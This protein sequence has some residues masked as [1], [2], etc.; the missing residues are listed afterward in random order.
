M[1]KKAKALGGTVRSCAASGPSATAS[2]NIC[3]DSHP[4]KPRLAIMV[5]AKKP[6]AFKELVRKKY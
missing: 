5:G 6:K 2:S 4:L 1:T 3:Y